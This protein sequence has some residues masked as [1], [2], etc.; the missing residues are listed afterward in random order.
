MP[1]NNYDY[2]FREHPQVRE[3]LKKLGIKFGTI[4]VGEDRD[5][6]ALFLPS[7]VAMAIARDDE[8]NGP[9]AIHVFTTDQ[10]EGN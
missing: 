9:G 8:G 10:F 5:W 7:G 6:P 4:D 1:K 2:F 3:E